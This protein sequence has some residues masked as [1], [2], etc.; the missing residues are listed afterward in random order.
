MCVCVCVCVCRLL[1]IKT[2]LGA[3]LVDLGNKARTGGGGTRG[4]EEKGTEGGFRRPPH[5]KAP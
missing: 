5:R 2:N 1:G 4:E 3:L